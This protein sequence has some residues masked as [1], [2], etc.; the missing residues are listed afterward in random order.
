MPINITKEL[1]FGGKMATSIPALHSRIDA[2]RW[3]YTENA[4]GNLKQEHWDYLLGKWGIEESDLDEIEYVGLDDNEIED[5]KDSGKE[6][7]KDVTGNDGKTG[8]EI[9]STSTTTLTTGVSVG[10]SLASLG[11]IAVTKGA[12]LFKN[13]GKIFTSGTKDA[14]GKV[15]TTGAFAIVALLAAVVSAINH[16]VAPHLKQNKESLETLNDILTSGQ[17]TMNEAQ[18]DMNELASQIMTQLNDAEKANKDGQ[19]DINRLASTT[20]LDA[21]RIASF[22]ARIANGEELTDEEIAWL[23]AAKARVGANKE[24]LNTLS[25]GITD[26][27]GGISADIAG[28]Q[29]KYEDIQVTTHEI[30]G[31]V[32]FTANLDETT[33]TLAQIERIS[34]IA[35]IASAAVAGAR[36]FQFGPFGWIGIGIAAGVAVMEGFAMKNQTEV[37]NVASTTIDTR[38]KTATLNEATI[39]MVDD[40]IKGNALVVEEVN[41]LKH[42]A[43]AEDEFQ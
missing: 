14:A 16:L 36:M 17:D 15:G 33:K 23:Q 11:G 42:T 20:A 1:N 12:G 32:E 10:F 35:N 25:Q 6:Q 26:T 22:E 41:S 3:A 18:D 8:D 43:V 24:E 39:S 31:I 37:I 38:I 7:A 34:S 5:A 4:K 27:V 28:N 9:A 30:A 13:I 21:I 40:E 29:A 2:L 19:Y